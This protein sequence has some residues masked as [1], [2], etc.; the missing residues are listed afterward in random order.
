MITIRRA[1]ARGHADHGWLQARHTFS[2]SEYVDPDYMGF[3]VLRVVNDDRIAPGGGFGMHPH[4]NMEIVTYILEGALRHQDSMGNGSVIR[5]GEIQYMSAG[6]GLYHS[7]FNA[8]DSAPVRLLQIWIQPSVQGA[9]PRYAQQAIPHEGR[10]GRWLTIASP[11]GREGSITI[12]QDAC[13][14][15]TLLD[16]DTPLQYRIAPGRRVYLQMA[17]GTAVLNGVTLH[18]GDGVFV[19]NEDVL[20]LS[21]GRQAEALLF[22]LP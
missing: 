16:S 8:S 7:E 21:E 4:R 2:F 15:A 9:E 3:S 12:R 14:M 1:D 22:D 17:G 20:T 13:V 11:D 6:K 19:E 10:N 5:A 18:D